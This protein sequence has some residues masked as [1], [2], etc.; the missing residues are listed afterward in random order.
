[1]LTSLVTFV[2]DVPLKRKILFHMNLLVIMGR[3]SESVTAV[4]LSE[5][6]PKVFLGCIP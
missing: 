1:M 4:A 5:I 2:C 3:I 6:R